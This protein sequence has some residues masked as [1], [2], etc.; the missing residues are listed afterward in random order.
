MNLRLTSLIKSVAIFMQ[1]KR[2]ITC[3]IGGILRM[4]NLS[5]LIRDI[6][7]FTSIYLLINWLTDE[8]V[9]LILIDYI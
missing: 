4:E 6:N 5:L 9:I 7:L 1:N 2:D 3:K 8:F